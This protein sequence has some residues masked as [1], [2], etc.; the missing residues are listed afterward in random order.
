MQLGCLSVFI[1]AATLVAAFEDPSLEDKKIKLASCLK[2]ITVTLK[3]DKDFL[4]DS[5]N[6]YVTDLKK[7]QYDDAFIATRDGLILTCFGEISMI[8][9]ADISSSPKDRVNP[10]TKE[11]KKLLNPENYQARY[12]EDSARRAKDLKTIAYLEKELQSEINQLEEAIATGI[13][14]FILEKNKIDSEYREKSKDPNKNKKRVEREERQEESNGNL[15]LFGVNLSNPKIKNTL[16]FSLLI[17]I[18][19]SLF[20]AFKHV[21]KK[22][23]P[24][25]KKEK[26]KNE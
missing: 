4:S 15:H 19:I 18:F 10:F 1:F 3:E 20:F 9:A 8:K 17:I 25:K 2:L 24:K 13:E 5:L 23:E 12:K 16:G 11:N 22:E 26:K 14:P 7:A 6:A 21:T